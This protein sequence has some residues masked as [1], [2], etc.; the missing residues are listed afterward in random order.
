MSITF[1]VWRFAVTIQKQAISGRVARL[2][3]GNPSAL[4]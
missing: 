2:A 4:E 3:A 1:R